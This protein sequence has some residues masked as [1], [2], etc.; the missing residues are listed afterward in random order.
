M[1][2]IWRFMC[3]KPKISQQK[4]IAQMVFEMRYWREEHW[5]EVMKCKYGLQDFGCTTLVI[6]GM[7][8]VGIPIL[9]FRRNFHDSEIGRVRILLE[10][11]EGIVLDRSVRDSVCWKG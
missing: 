10:N 7:A 2:K 11:A 6:A 1:Q 8:K 9:Q 5:K 4:F 3:Q